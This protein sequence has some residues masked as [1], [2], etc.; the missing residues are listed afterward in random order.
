MLVQLTNAGAALIAANQGPIQLSSFQLGTGYNYVPQPTATGL[1]GTEVASGAPS[2]YVTINANVVKYSVYLDYDAGPYTFGELGL[3]TSTGVLF[4]LA[5][6]STLISKIPVSQGAL[7][8]SIRLDVYLSMVGSNYAMWLDYASSSNQ[9]QLAVL[10]SVDQLPPP[11]SAVP[12]AYVISGLAAGQSAFTAVTDQSGLWSFDAYAYANQASAAITSFTSQSVTIPVADYVPGMTPEY[13]GQ[14]ILQFS[15]GELYG[16]C[17]YVS[18]AVTVGGYVTLGFDNPLML[19][20]DIGDT[21]VVFG[22]QALS[23]TIPNL[24]IATA[25]QLG[26]IKVGTSLEVASD[27]TLNV[28]PTSYPVISVNGQTGEVNLTATDITGLATVATT[29]QYSDLLGKPTPYTLPVASATVLGGVKA[30]SDGTLTIAGDG[31]IDLGFSPVKTVNGTG[32]DGTGNVTVTAPA[33]IGLVT[34]TQIAASTDFNTIQTCGLYFGL[35]ANAST[36]LNAPSTAAGGT[37]DVEPF[38]TTASGSDVIQRY[39]MSNTLYF[40]RYTQSTNTWSTW[41]QVATSSAVP[42]ATTTTLGGV[43]VGTGLAVT[44]GGLLSTAA[45][46][47]TTLG[48][49]IVGGGLAVTAG[50]ILSVQPYVLPAAT[51]DALGGILVGSGLGVVD[52]GVLSV[53]GSS[54]NS[55]TSSSSWWRTNADGTIEMGGTVSIASGSNSTVVNL[56]IPIP[57]AYLSGQCTDTGSECYA[58]AVS[59]LSLTEITVYAPAYWLDPTGTAVARGTADG[60][61]RI[62][63]N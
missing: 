60:Q 43:I 56:P 28:N 49:V 1:E 62:L 38:S 33:V 5:A 58:Y 18:T 23:T 41:T 16:I 27:G 37:L 24:P 36:F 44:S 63:C 40:R 4:A 53:N 50:G 9:F 7:G 55:L 31:T 54:S 11:Q 57:T 14:V 12:N 6:N 39:T 48:A 17:R 34:P 59:P 61:W 20:P 21:F 30:P 29:G 26:G 42:V 52:G 3:Y 25:N 45:A 15:S 51:V 2:P 32:P 35:D 8:N 19:T 13:V 10:Q 47:T 46:T 22:R